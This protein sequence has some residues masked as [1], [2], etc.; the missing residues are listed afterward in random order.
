M[1]ESVHERTLRPARCRC[2]RGGR[3]ARPLLHCAAGD[4]VSVG[5]NEQRRGGRPDGESP[6]GGAALRGSREP[7]KP[8]VEVAVQ[9]L[10]ERRL[11]RNPPVFSTLAAHMD[12]GAVVG[13][14]NIANV[15]ADQLV[16]T[17]AG[18]QGGKDDCAVAF[19]PVGAPP[20]ICVGVQGAPPQRP[21]PAW[22]ATT[23]RI[24]P[25]S[26]GR[27][28]L[29]SPVGSQTPR[30][31]STGPAVTPRLTPSRESR[32]VSFP[33]PFP[34]CGESVRTALS[35]LAEGSPPAS[36]A[37]LEVTLERPEAHHGGLGI[38]APATLRASRASHTSCRYRPATLAS[39][40]NTRPD[41]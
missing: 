34:P 23:R 39:R 27:S 10:N 31:R 33:N 28:P 36:Q 9:N 14:A 40:T 22:R 1:S 20:L 38:A 29:Q 3:H 4:S 21:S 17:Q 24:A 6:G 41:G 13:P 25:N 35:D 30:S 11:D 18:Q 12:D 5:A 8:S 32:R 37:T 16:G 15:G 26:I 7:R 19:D 2:R